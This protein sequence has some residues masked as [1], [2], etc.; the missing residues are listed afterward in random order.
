M[1]VLYSLARGLLTQ[2]K[3]TFG[4][5]WI[6]KQAAERMDAK[7]DHRLPMMATLRARAYTLL[8]DR[9][10]AAE[11]ARRAVAGYNGQKVPEST[12]KWLDEALAAQ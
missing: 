5:V 9:T 11:L 7:T 3:P 6:A 10:Q 2:D 1:P 4:E 12:Q 8:G